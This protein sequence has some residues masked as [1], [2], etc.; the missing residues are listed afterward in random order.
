MS[1]PKIAVLYHAPCFDGF[2][3]AWAAWKALGDKAVY[4]PVKYGETL[5]KLDDTSLV[6]FLDVTFPRSVMD[7]VASS[8]R[9]I[10]IDHHK[11]A[12]VDLEGFQET[13]FDLE[14]SGAMLAWEHF[15]PDKPVPELVKYVQDRDLW[16]F[17]LP[18]SRQITRWLALF[19]Y[20]FKAWDEAHMMLTYLRD[21]VSTH[22]HIA[23]QAHQQI[24]D[25]LMGNAR[26][27]L[28]GGWMVPMVNT[29]IEFG[30]D[31]AN[32]LL[33]LYPDAKFAGYYF[34]RGDGRRQWGLRSNGFDVSEVAKKYD[35]GGHT[36]AA[37]FTSS[38]NATLDLKDYATGIKLG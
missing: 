3:A 1:E 22:A 30:S 10:V 8:R 12:Q 31:A 23:M 33:E 29:T 26:M 34:D 20:T 2:T 11:T 19:P 35:G 17:E 32:M 14:K 27:M 24:L 38:Y 7:G 16:K 25:A 15:H 9:T 6:Y 28:V 36:K 5:P 13:I 18:E 21:D 4:L 37:G